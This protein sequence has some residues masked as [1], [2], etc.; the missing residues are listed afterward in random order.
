LRLATFCYL[1]FHWNACFYFFLSSIYGYEN[2]TLND[3]TFSYQKIPDLLFPLCETRFD[4]YRNECLFPEENWRYRFEKINELNNY[5]E[6]KIES[7]NFNN[8]TKKYAMSFY[9]SAL[10]LVTLG[11]QPWPENSVQTIFEIIDTIIGLLLFAAIIGDIGIMVSNAHLEKAKFQEITDGCKR[12]MRIRNV[13]NQLHNRVI[14]WIEYQWIWGRR[15]NESF[16]EKNL[17][18]FLPPCLGLELISESIVRSFLG[19]PIFS[20]CERSLLNEL[21]IKLKTL[22]LCPGDIVCRKGDNAKAM[23]IVKYGCLEMPIDEEFI[24]EQSSTFNNSTKESSPLN[25]LNNTNNDCQ[26]RILQEGDIFGDWALVSENKIPYTVRS[27]GYSLLFI[28]RRDDMALAFD[29]YPHSRRMV[30]RKSK[31]ISQQ[32]EQNLKR[33]NSLNSFDSAAEQYYKLNDENGKEIGSNF[34]QKPYT[35][36]LGKGQVIEGMDRA[37][38]GMCIGEKRRVTI[39]GKL[40]FGDEGRA[41]DGIT[42]DQVLHYV[43]QLKNLFRPIPGPKW[44]EEDG[45]SIEVTHKI[46]ESK[47]RRSSV[48]DTIHQHYTL[49]LADGTFIDSSH[50]RGEPFIFKLGKGEVIVGMDRAMTGMCEGE[51]RKVIIPSKLGY[52]SKGRDQIP[53]GAE[54]HFDIELAKLFKKAGSDEL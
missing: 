27:I 37:M 15:L 7:T 2:S 46:D 31:L 4:F 44:R 20:L 11:E 43:V 45:L 3:W 36:T 22:R 19:S 10:T 26:N 47:C 25:F 52:G 54:L 38:T 51:R 30:R 21:A 42:K 49:H 35:F 6:K 13:N 40:G 32:Y 48:G 50:S 18:K 53:G 34:N 17:F 24:V 5:W 9:W 12:Y 16:D 8:L 33:K 29:E 1:L 28:L 14:N 41:R 23:F 39:P